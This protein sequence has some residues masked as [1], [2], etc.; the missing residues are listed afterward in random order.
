MVLVNSGAHGTLGLPSEKSKTSLA[1]I[2]ARRALARSPI[3]RITD[4]PLSMAWYVALIMTLLFARVR[5]RRC[6]YRSA[7]VH[8]RL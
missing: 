4:L 3:M 2:C 8:R 7:C 1:P 6:H 5:L